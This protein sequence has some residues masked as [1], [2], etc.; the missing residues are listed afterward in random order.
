MDHL[1][2]EK[3][4]PKLLDDF[5]LDDNKKKLLKFFLQTENLNLLIIGNIC[6]GKTCILNILIN[7]YFDFNNSLIANNVLY[8]SSLKDNG[9]NYFRNDIKTFSQTNNLFNKKK[10]VIID[11]LEN[12]ND[13]SQYILL[14]L[15]NKYKYKINF[16]L[17]VNNYQKI[18]DGYLS[19]LNIINL[20]YPT[21]K[22]LYDLTK[23]ILEKEEI[24]IEINLIDDIITNSNNSIKNI[25]NIIEKF[26]L[27]NCKITKN[28]IHY[29]LYYINN[30]NFYNFT[31]YCLNNDYNN[32]INILKD[33]YDIG[34]S[35][36]DI[37]DSYSNYIK[38][39]GDF[40]EKIK[41]TIIKVLTKYIIIYH[42]INE[43][44]LELYFFVNKLI[45]HLQNTELF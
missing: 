31:T 40:T 29:F 30:N 1:I 36:I 22:Y 35:I 34:Y 12:I 2:F 3:Y 23:T 33:I 27:Y 45:D 42:N 18:L 17:T 15:I 13:Q 26:I 38:N 7:E 41:F 6:T 10:L 43:N 9:I 14:G 16:I 32:A 44:I 25:L 20:E 11:D 39:T 8:V 5:Y 4:K 19:H 21:Y 24:D 28:N 37:Y